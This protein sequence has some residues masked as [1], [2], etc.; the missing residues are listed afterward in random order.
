MSL[1]DLEIQPSQARRTYLPNNLGFQTTDEVPPSDEIIGQERAV[2]AL[3][4]GLHINEVGFNIYVAGAPG[5]GKATAVN[6][7]L[8]QLA[9]TQ[10]V[11][12]DWCYVYNFEDPYQPRAISLPAG[13]G[14]EFRQ[15]MK[16]F[17]KNARRAVPQAFSTKEYRQQREAILN[18]LKRAQEERLAEVSRLAQ[19]EQFM[20]QTTPMGLALIPLSDGKPMTDQQFVNLNPKTRQEIQE[21]RERLGKLVEQALQEIH[22]M[23]QEALQK[24]QQLDR[25][26]AHNAIR[27]QVGDLSS[28]YK[29]HEKV[30]KYLKTVEED[31]IQNLDRFRQQDQ[32]PQ[33]QM[34]PGFDTEDIFWRRYQVNLIVDNSSQNNTGAPVI[35]ELNPTYNNLFG[36]LE[37]EARMGT[38][39]TDFTLIKPGAMHKA[40][41]GYLVLEA[42]E[43]LTDLFSWDGLKRA[44]RNGKIGIEEMGERLGFVA[45]KGL[46]PEPIP[47]DTKV[48][49]IG[50]PM[51]YHLLYSLDED[52]NELFKVKA[53]FA[54]DMPFTE[55]SVRQY[56]VFISSLVHK[57]NLLPF[58]AAAVAKMVEHGARAASDQKKLLARFSEIADLV[59][60]ATFWARKD[61]SGVV[62]RKHVEKAISEKIYRSNM[63]QER[64]Q[65]MTTRGFL[66]IDTE[67]KVVGQV[68]GL[69][70]IE[71][72]DFSFGRPT[73]IT[74]SL[75]VGRAGVVDIEREVELAGPI[76]SKGV[77]ILEG[78]LHQRYAQDKPLSLS[79]RLVF[80][81]SY[82]EVE[83][84]SAS[85]AELY[86][87]L[88]RLSGLPV[89]QDLAVTGSINQRGELQAIGGV[90]EKVEGFFD[91][92]KTRGLTGT[93]GVI[94]P[95]SNVENLMLREDVV[96]SIEAGQFHI[97]AAET[98]DEGIEILTGVP[99][100]KAD[101]EG[102]FPSDTVNG[103]VDER[104]RALAE[105]LRAFAKEGSD[106]EDEG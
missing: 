96:E 59:R 9:K 39:H 106:E 1:N 12:P 74:A 90:N 69:S 17:L 66:K 7:F 4:F 87:L 22:E 26:V 80:E 85:S 98:V 100:G 47:L 23:E 13:K 45:S 6:N 60:E 40:N 88:S 34:P 70:V 86:A 54:P 57:E 94:I 19:Q 38:L 65:E 33:Q 5:T 36:R 89:R 84:D 67:G 78:L 8:I 68:N 2:H 101:K 76:Y 28:K 51:L 55:E 92:C 21:K 103:M 14:K 24:I 35:M 79:A 42:R 50:D 102:K 44:L 62:E 71:L 91:L 29:E 104:L 25:E 61:D 3:E 82:S 31:I 53:D 83:G 105:G 20:L 32:Q 63:V 16:Q 72:G 97:Y 95:K 52:F 77:L 93:Q 27:H 37:K 15:D 30:L 48:L 46:R 11:P 99:A 18:G 56:A 41:G 43:V 75:G 64:L 73:R 10:P 49:L 58:T 81:Q